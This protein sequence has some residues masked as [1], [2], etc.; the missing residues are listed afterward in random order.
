ML[1]FEKP[2]PTVTATNT[3]PRPMLSVAIDRRSR[4][5]S[6]GALRRACQFALRLRDINARS[7]VTSEGVSGSYS[8][9]DRRTFLERSAPNAHCFLR[10]C[11][12]SWISLGRW[13]P[14]GR[15]VSAAMRARLHAHVVGLLSD[16]LHLTS[17]DAVLA[18][19]PFVF[20]LDSA[21]PAPRGPE[22][23][24]VGSAGRTRERRSGIRAFRLQVR[25]FRAQRV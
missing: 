22:A 24:M 18:N 13:P 20:R 25:P 17:P 23:R 2:V 8:T 21:A 5:D 10:V 16:R 12:G 1:D 7:W 3:N 9:R 4:P 19:G 15:A 14:P 11:G 6:K